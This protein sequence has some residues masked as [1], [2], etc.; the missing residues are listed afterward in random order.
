M[1]Y[2]FESINHTIKCPFYE[3]NLDACPSSS[4]FLSEEDLDILLK[5]CVTEEYK[6]CAVYRK[7]SKEKAA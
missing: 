3:K 6:K 7:V 4:N 5:S 1:T 2:K